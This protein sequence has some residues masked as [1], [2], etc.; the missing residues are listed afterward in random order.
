MLGCLFGFNS[1]LS[2]H[3][4]F[5]GVEI[6]LLLTLITFA[7]LACDR[8][9][10]LQIYFT[11]VYAQLDKENK[12]KVLKAIE[13]LNKLYNTLILIATHDHSIIGRNPMYKIEERRIE[14]CQ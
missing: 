6:G 14:K 5:L 13:K 3:W 11:K 10:A 4:F 7:N 1:I 9:I 2:E 12:V 8:R